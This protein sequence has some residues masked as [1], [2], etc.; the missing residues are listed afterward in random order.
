M[1]G[2]N[3]GP[4]PSVDG[5]ESVDC[6]AAMHSPFTDHAKFTVILLAPQIDLCMK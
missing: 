6:L 3:R 2:V 4:R 5:L 1:F